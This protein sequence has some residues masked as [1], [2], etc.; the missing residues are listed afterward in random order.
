MNREAEDPLGIVDVA[1]EVFW[2]HG[3]SLAASAASQPRALGPMV[4][5]VSAAALLFPRAY[6]LSTIERKS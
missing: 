3:C 6:I 4:G 1:R 2:L 5:R